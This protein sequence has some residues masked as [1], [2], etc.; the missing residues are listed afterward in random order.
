MKEQPVL[1]HP[2]MAAH[3]RAQIARLAAVLSAEENRAAAA[4]VLRSLIDRI[5]LT[6]NDQGKLE[7]DL[8]GDL[9]GILSLAANDDGRKETNGS[10]GRSVNLV[11]QVKVAAGARNHLDL[12][13]FA[14]G[15]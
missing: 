10:S 7:I 9:A 6:P 5:A 12:F 15:S 1:L 14:N 8:Y 13:L 4:D 3:Y 2:G 11:Q